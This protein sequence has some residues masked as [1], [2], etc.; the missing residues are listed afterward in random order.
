MLSQETTAHI[1]QIQIWSIERLIVYARNPRK[2]DVAVD[3]MCASIGEFGFR[4]PV[5][6]LSDSELVDGLH[7]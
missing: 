5:L 4:S 1:T 2:N 3:R 7:E 6:D